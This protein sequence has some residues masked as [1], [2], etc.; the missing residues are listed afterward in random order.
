[1]AETAFSHPQR[2]DTGVRSETADR[3]TEGR[4]FR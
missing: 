2:S 4:T 3:H 1:M